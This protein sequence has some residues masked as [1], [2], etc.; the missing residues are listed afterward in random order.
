MR[1]VNLFSTR[2][3]PIG[4]VKRVESLVHWVSWLYVVTNS[5]RIAFYA[6]QISAVC[7][8]VDGAA[9]V[10]LTRGASR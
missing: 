5:V 2:W 3:H 7:R 4:E 1:D 6:P 8:A 9:A 10:S